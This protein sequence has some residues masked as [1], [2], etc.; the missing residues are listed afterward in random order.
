MQIFQTNYFARFGAQAFQSRVKNSFLFGYIFIICLNKFSTYVDVVNVICSEKV[1]VA[2]SENLNFL[3]QPP[4]KIVVLINCNLQL[5]H[6]FKMLYN[7]TIFV[8]DLQPDKFN[9]KLS[10]CCVFRVL[11]PVMELLSSYHQSYSGYS[12]PVYTAQENFIMSNKFGHTM[13][14]SSNE[15]S[16][17]TA[18]EK[19]I[20][21]GGCFEATR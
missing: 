19:K 4:K 17:P 20:N 16:A 5:N 8:F 1:F 11:T 3:G 10:L 7:F 14:I 18:I 15:E 9:R 21:S 12:P 6:S 13:E 2:F